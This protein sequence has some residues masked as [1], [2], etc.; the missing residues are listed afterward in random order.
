MRNTLILIVLALVF[1]AAGWTI[2]RFVAKRADEAKVVTNNAPAL[3][4]ASATPSAVVTKATPAPGSTPVATPTPKAVTPVVTTKSG[5]SVATTASKKLPTTG[6]G[7]VAAALA[8][9]VGSLGYLGA[10]N[11]KLRSNIKAAYKG[12]SVL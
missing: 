11:R 10:M 4:Q 5:T 7:E 12:T 9:G 2:Y 6:P 8:V 1:F 3:Q